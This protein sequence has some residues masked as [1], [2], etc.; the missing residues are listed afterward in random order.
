[1]GDKCK[2]VMKILPNFWVLGGGEGGGLGNYL[3]AF[4]PPTKGNMQK[5]LLFILLFVP[6]L[7]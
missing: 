6:H 3:M 5:I 7:C 2:N 1:M 4:S